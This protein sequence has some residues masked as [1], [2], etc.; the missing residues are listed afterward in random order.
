APAGRDI[1]G[2]GIVLAMA[3]QDAP[4]IEVRKLT[5]AFG[6]QVALRGVD[7]QVAEGEF[8]ALFGPNGAGKTTLMRIIASL[9]RP[10]GGTVR[11]CGVELGKAGT[12][13]RRQI[14]LISHNPLLYGDLT[15]DENLRFFARMYDL[16]DAAA[17]IDA[18]LDQVGLAARRHDPVRTFSRGMVQRLAIARAI[19]H[20]PAIMLLDEPYTGLDQDA[21]AMLDAVLKQIAAQGR[22]VV[23]TSHDLA[24]AADLASRFDVLSRGVIAAS[25]QR[26][27]IDPDNLLA[28]YRQAV[29]DGS[30]A[31][32]AAPAVEAQA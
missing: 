12:S 2:A 8:L 16:P 20:D 24:R 29:G 25:V 23:M 9:A 21:S 15:P 31:S 32:L 26:S 3:V 28:F 18:V 1:Q 14:G 7:L 30:G 13:L 10:T 4:A 6:H 11:V 5:K 22:T 27:Q 19:L 17:R